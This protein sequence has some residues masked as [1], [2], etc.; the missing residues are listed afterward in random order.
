MK[1]G[2][3][4]DIHVDINM[5]DG[6]EVVSEL[7]SVEVRRV[8]LDILVIAGDISN[9]YRLSLA[10]V[11]RLSAE[12]GA[13]VLFVPGNHD[14]WNERYPGYTAWDTYGAL[15]AHPSNLAKGPVFLDG[16]WAIVGD[17]GWYDYSYGD[18]SFTLE[19]FDRMCYGERTWQ[20]KLYSIWGKSTL[21][22][23]AMFLERLVAALDA[24]RGKN[25]L[26]AT[27]MVQVP[28][29][30]VFPADSMWKYFNAFLGSPEYG[31]LC[32]ERGVALAVCGHVHYRRKVRKGGTEFVCPCLGY[33]TEWTAPAD[34]AAEIAK[35]LVVYELGE[36][37]A[38]PVPTLAT[39]SL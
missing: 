4:S 8:G 12:S 23:H 26:L 34:P 18:L 10:T 16:N 27:H 32:R 9:D 19:D 22:V 25:I 20:D 15:L 38:I 17:L 6:K 29:F 24:V 13:H 21:E 3:I 31:A 5:I 28:E 37:D 14:I 11:D 7:L 35:T 36:D 39:S 30:T 1:I 33:T 2:L